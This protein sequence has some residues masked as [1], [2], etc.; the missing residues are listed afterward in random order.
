MIKNL[1][2]A[3]TLVIGMI[4]LS[5]TANAQASAGAASS[6]TIIAPISIL[7]NTDMNFGSVVPSA[8]AGT[9][10]LAANGTRTATSVQISPT[11][12]TGSAAQFTVSGEPN[13]LFT[14]T[15]PSTAVTLTNTTGAGAETMTATAFTSNGVT[16]L[17]ATGQVVLNVGATLNVAANQ[18]KGI[19]NTG[20]TPFTVT[21]AYN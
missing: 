18:V 20:T 10:V 5:F 7:K 11:Q 17:D 9:V 3:L 14:V 12:A 6:A 15:L 21:V 1:T 2:K 19:Y 16:Q 8:A 4:G 13:Y